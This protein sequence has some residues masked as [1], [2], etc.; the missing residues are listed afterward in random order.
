MLLYYNVG[1][2]GRE[3]TRNDIFMGED[4]LLADANGNPLISS[5]TPEHVIDQEFGFRWQ[6]NKISLNANVYFMN[7][8]NEIVLNGNFGSNGLALT[9]KVEQSIR[10]GFE[11]DFAYKINPYFALKNNSSFNYSRIKEQSIIFIPILTPQF[12]V[13]QDIIYSVKN[14]TTTL[15]GRYQSRSYIDFANIEIIKGYFLL[16]ARV[17][18]QWEK[19]IFGIFGNNLTNAKYFNYGYV[20][21]DGSK[22]YFV[23]SG[24]NF[25][26]SII[27]SF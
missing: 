26:G 20:D 6:S 27:Y 24:I 11:I 16:N 5:T 9:E 1:M 12:I 25:Y 17:D 19:F 10:T 7:F 13:N 2:A 22:K 18:Y 4:D 14:F 15:S 8:D 21:F 23:Q 3:P